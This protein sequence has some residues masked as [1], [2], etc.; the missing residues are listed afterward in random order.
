MEPLRKILCVAACA[1]APPA[2]GQ[3][4]QSLKA[5]PASAKPGE[6]VSITATF[7]ISKGL[8]CNVRFSF[9]DGATENQKVNQEKDA[10]L[11][12]RH[13]Y[14]KPGSYTVKVEP[15]TA[16]PTL[17]CLGSNQQTVVQVVAATAAAAAAPGCPQGWK[18]QARSVNKKTGAYTCSAKVGTPVPAD[19]P[20]CPG[21]LS[22][23][24]NGKKG[25]LGCKP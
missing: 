12:V 24:E 1:L 11:T 18:L 5:E 6:P 19:H 14:A 2:F 4:L 23:F 9:G 25:Q 21:G 13:S 16:L 10:R 15:K 20:A 8:N 3:A 7:D 17:K 22:Y